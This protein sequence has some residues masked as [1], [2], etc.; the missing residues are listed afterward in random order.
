MWQAWWSFLQA[1]HIHLLAPLAFCG[2]SMAAAEGCSP[3]AAWRF[4][5]PLGSFSQVDSAAIETGA[6]LYP[7]E[8]FSVPEIWLRPCELLALVA[9]SGF[10]PLQNSLSP[11]S[12]A[13]PPRSWLIPIHCS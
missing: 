3:R 6:A 9:E 2:Q 5:G 12:H 11:V 10:A 8:R 1:A 7:T 13:K 4:V